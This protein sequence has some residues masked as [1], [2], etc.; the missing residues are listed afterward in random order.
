MFN[1]ILHFKFIYIIHKNYNCDNLNSPPNCAFTHIICLIETK[2]HHASIDVHKFI[3]S[4]KY[5]YISI[6]DGHGLMMMYDIH[7]HLDS[8]NTITN[9]GLEYIVATFNINT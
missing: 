5:S 1:M 3:N 7:M 4:L 6:H 9:D 2:I 8:F